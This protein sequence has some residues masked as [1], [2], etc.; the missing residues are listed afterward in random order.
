MKKA[1]W[2]VGARDLQKKKKKPKSN[3]LFLNELVKSQSFTLKSLN[4]LVCLPITSGVHNNVGTAFKIEL[5][6]FNKI[7]KS[8]GDLLGSSKSKHQINRWRREGRRGPQ[9]GME[10]QRGGAQISSAALKVTLI[11]LTVAPPLKLPRVEADRGDER[12]GESFTAPSG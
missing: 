9:R 11:C 10:G 6:G 1:H 2:D 5:D 12:K 8:N 7:L 4:L 3:F